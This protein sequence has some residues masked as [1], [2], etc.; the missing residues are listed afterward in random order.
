VKWQLICLGKEECGNFQGNGVIF[1][2]GNDIL[3]DTL[4][5]MRAWRSGHFL[6]KMRVD[7]ASAL[8]WVAVAKEYWCISTVV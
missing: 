2:A 5:G 6:L 3:S 1:E 7:Q 4:M 8:A